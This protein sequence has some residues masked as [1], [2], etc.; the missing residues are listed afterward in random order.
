M[1]HLKA[2][3]AL[4]AGVTVAACDPVTIGAAAGLAVSGHRVAC[5]V[6]TPAARE[7]IAEKIHGGP[8][9]LACPA[10]IDRAAGSDASGGAPAGGAS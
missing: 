8:S 7:A 4:L 10:E 3:A 1:K 9:I 6:V 2:A 5:A